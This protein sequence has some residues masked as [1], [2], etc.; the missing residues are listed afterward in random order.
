MTIKQWCVEEVKLLAAF[1]KEWPGHWPND[2]E[3]GDW[4]EQYSIWADSRSDDET[5][6]SD[7]A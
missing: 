5:V 4:D 6:P 7:N 1:L 2:L 3:P